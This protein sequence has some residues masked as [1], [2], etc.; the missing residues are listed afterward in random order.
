MNFGLILDFETTGIDPNEDSIIEI[1]LLEFALPDDGREPQILNM[2]GAL[3]DPGKPLSPEIQKLTGLNDELLRGHRIGWDFVRGITERAAIIIAHNADFDRGFAE[4][5]P[6]L[7]GLSS[8]WACSMKHIDWEGKGFRTRALNY[9]AADH[10]FVNA[11]AHRALFDCATTFRLIAPYLPE[12]IQ[13]SYLR[14]VRI[15]A[16]AAPFEVKDKLRSN[17]Y[18]WDNQKRVWFKDVL[19]DALD[20][21]REFLKSEV[22]QGLRDAHEE[23]WIDGAAAAAPQ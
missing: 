21:E 14:E 3:E 17:R 8:H 13:R 2:Y 6:E 5:R 10:G 7:A 12:L 15:A 23:L 4:R 22:Y 11:F 19:E 18:R 16:V 9:L 20:G 1:G